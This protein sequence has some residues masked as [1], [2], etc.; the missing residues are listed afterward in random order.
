MNTAG[1]TAGGTNLTLRMCIG[2]SCGEMQQTHAGR[3]AHMTIFESV[4]A[5]VIQRREHGEEKGKEE[6]MGEK[7]GERRKEEYGRGGER[8]IQG[9]AWGSRLCGEQ[10][11]IGTPKVPWALKLM[12]PPPLWSL[13]APKT[14]DG[15]R[16]VQKSRLQNG[17][18]QT[19]G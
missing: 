2:H 18:T 3:H 16:E 7:R 17:L 15:D 10:G 8:G 1:G 19:N 4:R 13:L 11:W 9:P 12:P 6:E 5:A 14:Q